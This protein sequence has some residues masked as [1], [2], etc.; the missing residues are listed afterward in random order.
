M[1]E[2]VSLHC[3][4]ELI[5]GMRRLSWIAK[6][7]RCLFRFLVLLSLIKCSKKHHSFLTFRNSLTKKVSGKVQKLSKSQV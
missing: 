6:K 5:N 7:R 3:I 2:T 4:Q 1:H